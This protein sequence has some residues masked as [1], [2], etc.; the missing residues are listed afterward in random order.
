MVPLWILFVGVRYGDSW[1][2]NSYSCFKRRKKL[3]VIKMI[4]ELI[5][6]DLPAGL[7][8]KAIDELKRF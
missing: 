1:Q 4:K 8:I 5:G 3:A 2:K 6:G 7:T